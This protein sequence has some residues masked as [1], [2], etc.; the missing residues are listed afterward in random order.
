MKRMKSLLFALT[1]MLGVFFIAGCQA[2]VTHN[3]S[4]ETNAENSSNPSNAKSSEGSK[5]KGLGETKEDLDIAWIHMTSAAQS[6]Q[7]ARDGFEQYIKE[8]GYNWNVNYADSKGSGQ[9]LASNIE[10][11]VQRKVDAIIISMADLRA[12]QNSI[13]KAESAGIPI[14]SVDSGWT[15][16]IVVDVTSNNYVMSSKVSSYLVDQLG[17]KGKIVAFK[18]AEHHGVR[19]RGEVLDLIVKENPGIEILEEH[20]IDY[21][22]FYEDTLKTMEDYIA[23]YGDEID[24]VWAGWDEPA[25][26][27]AAAIE[28]AGLNTEIFVTGIDG[29]PPAIEE[30]KKGSPIDATV[31]QGFEVMGK[32]IATYIYELKTEG[33]PVDE[34]I[35]S[36]TVYVDTP[37]VTKKNLP[38][39]GQEAYEAEDFYSSN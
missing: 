9:T 13:E 25:M 17:G 10:D 38:K 15:P 32:N 7:R 8:K 12:A 14:F 35:K 16:G 4:T 19:K 18:M 33:K 20:N 30:M 22:N 3:A 27:A 39:E 29:H 24:A 11:A 34:V 37:L 36:T 23:R 6:E 28:A 5:S 21:A 1:V 2:D 31:A 26:A